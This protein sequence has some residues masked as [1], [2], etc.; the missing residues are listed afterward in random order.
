MA[1]GTPRETT[2]Q[3]TLAATSRFPG[4]KFSPT[5]EELITYYLRKKHEGCDKS[6]EVIAEVEICRYEPWDLPGKSVIPSDNE[7]F[8]F[9][10]RGRKYPNGKQSRRATELGYWKAT[11]KER[12]VKVGH[13]VIGTKRTL[14]FHK[15]R[16]PKGE[17]TEWIMHEFCMTGKSQ[18]SPIICRL[19]K[20]IEFRS[21]EGMNA[22]SSKGPQLI[23]GEENH[24]ASEGDTEI[25]SYVGDEFVRRTTSSY[26]SYSAD[27]IESTSESNQRLTNEATVTESSTR[28][29]DKDT[30]DDGDDVEDYFA[31]ILKDDIIK[32]DETSITNVRSDQPLELSRLEPQQQEPLQAVYPPPFPTITAPETT[33]IATQRRG[34]WTAV[35]LWNEAER[36]GSKEPG[37]E[38]KEEMPTFDWSPTCSF[39]TM[40]A[41]KTWTRRILSGSVIVVLVA[42]VLAYLVS[43]R[44]QT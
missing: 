3:I 2:Q 26:G 14:V 4:F 10:A 37:L 17:R 34:A 35:G 30:D 5:D 20:N 15:G 25:P 6:V 24:M 11:G 18:D 1:E 40:V 8:F 9:S 19:R 32:L 16:A 13:H 39:T 42:V 33:T 38:D 21:G 27:Q 41:G 23:A 44:L 7:W 43:Q 36:G 12:N 22:S 28:P 31:D 29:K